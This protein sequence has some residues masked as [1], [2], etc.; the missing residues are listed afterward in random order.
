MRVLALD[1]GEARCGVAISDESQ[2]LATPIDPIAAPATRRGRGRIRALV[3]EV[4]AER[5]IVGLPTPLSGSENE[6]T[7]Q[8]RAFASSLAALL[9]IPVELY[10]E[11]FTTTLANMRGGQ[12]SEDSRAAAVLLQEWLDRYRCS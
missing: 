10:D 8:T 3:T 6:Q 4:G 11:R 9:S 7:R 1:F 12:T 2:T 5:V